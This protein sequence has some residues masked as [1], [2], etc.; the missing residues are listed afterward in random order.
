MDDNAIVT[1]DELTKAIEKNSNNVGL[2]EEQAYDLA[3]H[4]LNFF[5]YSDRIIDNI[6]EPED[7]DA[8]YILEDANILTTE[9]EETTLYDGREWRIHYWIFRQGKIREIING[10][11]SR[12]VEDDD[13]NDVYGTM[14]AEAWDRS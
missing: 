12:P 3:K 11:G 7:R 5:G 1:V 10:E 2:S 9:R 8:M 6:L 4:V 13:D 14:P